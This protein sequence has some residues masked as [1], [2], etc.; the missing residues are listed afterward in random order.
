MEL[1]PMLAACE[2]SDVD[3]IDVG[4]EG[5]WSQSVCTVWNRRDGWLGMTGVT[6]EHSDFKP[7]VELYFS[8]GWIGLHCFQR[9]ENSYVLD[10][11]RLE[12]IVSEV[13]LVL[14]TSADE[15]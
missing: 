13:E 11:S 7:S 4:L 10:D 12:Q 6:R 2:T 15:S 3:R 5:S 9:L 14:R 8:D 1:Q